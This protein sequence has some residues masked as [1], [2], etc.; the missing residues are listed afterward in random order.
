MWFK[1]SIQPRPTGQTLTRI[2]IFQVRSYES[3]TRDIPMLSIS[4]FFATLTLV[5]IAQCGGPNPPPLAQPRPDTGIRIPPQPTDPC[6]Q[7]GMGYTVV[8]RIFVN[9]PAKSGRNY[10]NYVLVD[11]SGRVTWA[12]HSTRVG[13]S[14]YAGN[15]Y[16]YQLEGRP[17]SQYPDLLIV[18]TLTSPGG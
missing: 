3:L 17:S 4:A 15:N 14:P 9:E 5:V 8:G 7:A 18:C 6:E 12:L 1:G 11:Q 2:S 16:N 13:L 10:G